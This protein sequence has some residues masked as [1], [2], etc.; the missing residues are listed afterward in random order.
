MCSEALCEDYETWDNP[1]FKLEIREGIA[2]CTLNRPEAN[3]AMNGG[4]GGGQSLGA[5]SVWSPLAAPAGVCGYLAMVCFE[6]KPKGTRP[7]FFW[8]GRVVFQDTP[9]IMSSG[10]GKH[11][12]GLLYVA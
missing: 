1:E 4:I 9:I 3:N 10:G 12:V 6:G 7:V 8:G 2:Y 11:K 5:A